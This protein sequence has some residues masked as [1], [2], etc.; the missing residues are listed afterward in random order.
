L[1]DDRLTDGRL[2]AAVLALPG[3]QRA[4]V[5]LYY[6]EDR[7]TAEVAELVGCSEATVRSHL[8][9]ARRRL[10]DLLDE[11]DEGDVHDARR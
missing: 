4:V 6:L 5:A 3:K 8:R 9:A 7:P 2:W 10:A 1:D 11:H